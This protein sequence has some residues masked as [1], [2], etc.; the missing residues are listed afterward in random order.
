VQREVRHLEAA[1]AKF[2]YSGMRL[3]Q[4]EEQRRVEQRL[5]RA[6]RLA[7]EIQHLVE[8][9]SGRED[10]N[11]HELRRMTEVLCYQPL[12]EVPLG[13]PAALLRACGIDPDVAKPE[14]VRR[15]ADLIG[16][17]TKDHERLGQVLERGVPHRVLNA[18]YH[19]M[20]AHIIAQAGR[21]GALTI[22]TNM[23]GRGVDILLGGNPNELANEILRREGVDPEQ[24]SD[25]QHQAALT[26]AQE[27]CVK[28]REKVVAVGGLHIL[29][30]ERHE[31]RRIDNQLRG[32]AGRQGDPG[33]S[34]FYVS[35][36]DELMRL[37]GPERLDWFLGRWPENEPIEHKWTSKAIENAQ[38]KVEAH[39]FEI[40]KH[41][42]QYDDIMN[43]QR[44]LIYEQR[45]RVLLGED[46]RES[47]IS[48]LREFMMARV[49]EFASP[50]VHRSEW[51]LAALHQAL[52]EALPLKVTVEDLEQFVHHEDLVEFLQEQALAVYEE[53]E[54]LVGAEQMREIERQ[55][56]LWVV[57][58]CWIDHIAAMEDL[59]EGIGLRGYAGVDPLVIY[60]KESYDYWQN[61]LARVQEEVVR[62]MFRFKIEPQTKRPAAA[63][64]MT[65]VPQG[66]PVEA[67][68]AD[69]IAEPQAP[70]GRPATATAT[71]PVS[72]RRGARPTGKVGRNAPCPCGS[73]L[74]YKKCCGR[75]K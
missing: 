61:L 9:L 26:E 54:A 8:R 28:D 22:A 71:R 16:L 74:K 40:R 27:T 35:F 2:D 45:R 29:G 58:R 24:A 62:L 66:Q 52:T 51:N 49:K 7:E 6:S 18:K 25:E 53:R 10:P 48:Q 68:E 55:I 23:A 31:S 37:F 43:H 69:G 17:E 60:R 50:E 14:N 15:L 75:G 56:T 30:T 19:E 72:A 44:A 33:S 65:S 3:V 21:S 4:P 70:A 46:M 20:E 47:V 39:N 12:E 59:E 63:A 5:A 41:R 38:K 67:E 32:R 64:S 42:L 11:N 36:E 13:R 57:S 73:G 34:R 1:V